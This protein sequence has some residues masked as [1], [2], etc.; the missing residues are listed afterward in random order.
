[1]QK[2]IDYDYHLPSELIATHPVAPREAA[3]LL[4]WPAIQDDLTFAD[5]PRLLNPGDVLV[6][7]NS[8]VIPA[9]LHCTRPSETHQHGAL[10]T[11]ILLHRPIG[12]F[13]TW[14]VFAQKTKR[15]RIGQQFAFYGWHDRRYH[16][17][18]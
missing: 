12:D 5:L 16:R 18:A 8:R 15:L 17:P 10:Q 2:P 9:R 1:M 3:R 11:E 6:F 13:Q 14:E 4:P 7:N